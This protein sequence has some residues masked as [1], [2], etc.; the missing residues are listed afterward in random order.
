MYIHKSKEKVMITFLIRNV[1][2]P[3][4]GVYLPCINQHLHCKTENKEGMATLLR[5]DCQ[6]ITIWKTAL[7]LTLINMCIKIVGAEISF[8]NTDELKLENSNKLWIL[9]F[10]KDKIGAGQKIF[11]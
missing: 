4:I 11:S 3:S 5:D 10:N 7:K 6:F 2:Y 9:N 1:Q 8:W